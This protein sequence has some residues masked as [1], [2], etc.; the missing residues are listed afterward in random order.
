MSKNSNEFQSTF[1]VV[2]CCCLPNTPLSFSFTITNLQNNIVNVLFI[3][4]L[5]STSGVRV[6][7]PH[8]GQRLT[9]DTSQH[10]QTGRGGS[11]GGSCVE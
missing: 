11:W 3:C 9:Q 5:P 10:T 2:K 1:V 6:K 8:T 4:Y 7:A